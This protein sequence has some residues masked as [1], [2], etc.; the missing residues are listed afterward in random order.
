MAMQKATVGTL[1]GVAATGVLIT[2]LVSALLI[3]N[4]TIPNSGSIK[5]I[6]IQA[7][8]DSNFTN[9]TTSINWATLEPNS[10]KSY[11]IYIRNNGTAAVTLTMTTANWSSTAAQNYLT[12]S[13]NRQNYVLNQSAY[14]QATLTLT[15]SPVIT[16]VTTFSFD[17]ILTGTET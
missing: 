8:W 4:R 3:T 16:G 17:I 1:L 6:G 12:L 15:V 2:A 7:Y 9:Q 14:V 5:T 10:S 11:T 13:W